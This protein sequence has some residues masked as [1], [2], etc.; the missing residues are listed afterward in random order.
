MAFSIVYVSLF[1]PVVAAKQMVTADHISQ[2]RFGLNLVCGWNHDEFDML[3]VDLAH[4]SGTQEAQRFGRKPS[5]DA[6][7]GG[8]W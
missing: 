7:A 3:G 5:G 1:N 6:R 2:G 4:G 8:E